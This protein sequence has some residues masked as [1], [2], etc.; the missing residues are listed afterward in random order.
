MKVGGIYL[1]M[2]LTLV[3]RFVVPRGG[4]AL[5]FIFFS[6]VGCWLL[7]VVVAVGL[8]LI[9]LSIYCLLVDVIELI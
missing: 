4:G 2:L 8:M 6:A 1:D 3:E 9:V 5:I 7:A